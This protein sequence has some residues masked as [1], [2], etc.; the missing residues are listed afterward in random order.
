MKLFATT[1]LVIK[2]TGDSFNTDYSFIAP[3]S[4]LDKLNIKELETN[5]LE[6]W[7]SS[8]ADIIK[9]NVNFGRQKKQ[10]LVNYRA[11]KPNFKV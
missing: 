8:H 9:N 5:W 3:E 10:E 2:R 7:W 4:M 1:N 6:S 11:H